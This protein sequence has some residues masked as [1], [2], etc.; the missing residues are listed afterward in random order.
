MRTHRD[1]NHRRIP[2]NIIPYMH[3]HSACFVLRDPIPMQSLR[4]GLSVTETGQIERETDDGELQA[5]SRPAGRKRRRTKETS[6]SAAAGYT[7]ER[8]GGGGRKKDERETSVCYAVNRHQLSLGARTAWVMWGDGG[9][10][11]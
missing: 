3:I 10:S 5:S 4:V 8:K 11:T 1:R 6:Q 9:I 7:Q 2:Q